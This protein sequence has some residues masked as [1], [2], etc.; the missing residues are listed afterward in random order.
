MSH[1]RYNQDISP[2]YVVGL[3]AATA[4][5]GTGEPSERVDSRELPWQH[6]IEHHDIHGGLAGAAERR[7]TG[8]GEAHLVAEAAQRQLQALPGGWIVLDQ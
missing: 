7:L 4:A 1:S 8:F 5:S 6:H 2:S 3:P